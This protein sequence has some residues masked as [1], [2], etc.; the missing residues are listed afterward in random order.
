[1]QSKVFLATLCAALL[2]GT[3]AFA[4]DTSGDDSNAMA[5]KKWPLAAKAGV[6][7][8]ADKVAPPGAVNQ[9]AFNM[10][11]WK[12]GHT[13]DPP[14]GGSP[15]WNPV[16]V[17][18]MAGGKISSITVPSGST[19][20]IYCQAANQ[21]GVD[22]IWTELQHNEGTWNE[23]YNMWSACPH[24]KA[25][26]GVRVP[27][28]N[29]YDEQHAMDNGALVLVI[30][31]VRSV[32][33]AK[34]AVKWAY[35][36]PMGGR[37]AGGSRAEFWGQV[38]GGYHNT[39]ND[40]LVLVLMIETLDGLRDADKIAATKGVSAVFAASGDQGNFGGYKQG[41]PDYERQINIIH[42]AA[43]RAH[44]KLWGPWAWNGRGDFTGFQG[45]GG[46]E[47]GALVNTA[48]SK[49]MLPANFVEL[50]KKA[51]GPLYDTQGKPKTGPYFP[52]WKPEPLPKRAA[53][54]G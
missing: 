39:I 30:P 21:G 1:M 10:N 47:N 42:D 43:L 19:P 22:Y 35:F 23:I 34:E 51:L 11:S 36:P 28:A 7:S 8:H 6:D 13:F 53:A 24:A 45:P 18:M 41:D 31:T 49:A 32:A 16:K 15:I 33:E 4:Q 17:K 44:V 40:N 52:G 3:Y 2:A 50:Q 9:G 26:P 38:P 12:R 5:Q 27:N 20:Q 29:E 25:V 54:A 14:A 37:S 48:T 46:S